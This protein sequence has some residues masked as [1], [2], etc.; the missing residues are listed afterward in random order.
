MEIPYTLT[1]RP[2]TGLYNGKLG[3]W[4]FLASE[5]MLFGA[6]FT[7]YLFMRIGAEDGTWPQHVL[8]VPIGFTNT[9]ILIISS[10]TMVF[11]WVALKERKLAKCRAFLAVTIL[12]GILFLCLKGYEYY[13]KYIHWG[14]LIKE[15]AI[16]KYMPE[17]KKQDVEVTYIPSLHAY[18]V[19]GDLEDWKPGPDG[20]LFLTRF[21]SGYTGDYVLTP[22]KNFHPIGYKA[23]EESNGTEET[24]TISGTDVDK[25]GRF[26]PYYGT[27]FA[28]YFTV[29]GLHALHIIGG[30]VVMTYF[31]TIGSRLYK[32]NPEQLSNRLE[33]T[34]IFWHFVDLVWITV[35]PILYLT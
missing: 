31:L 22:V 35:F 3:I 28:I 20:D 12:C 25:A 24:V 11:A 34:G 5:V 29:T 9:C 23:P 21:Q 14:L 32:R 26:L 16:A 15:D 13:S 4:L 18:Q 33:V 27:Y 6:L 17:L 1:A 8:S 10:I 19:S 2:D 7:S 30:C